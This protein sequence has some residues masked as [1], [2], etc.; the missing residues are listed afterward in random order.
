L[1]A[2]AGPVQA[3]HNAV[4]DELIVADAFDGGDVLDAG[5]ALGRVFGP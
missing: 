1:L 4:A 2:V 3:D 5:L